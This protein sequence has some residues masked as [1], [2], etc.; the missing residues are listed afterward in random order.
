MS[1]LEIESHHEKVI[2]PWQPAA[3][4]PAPQEEA[5]ADEEAQQPA[6]VE[7]AGPDAQAAQAQLFGGM[8]GDTEPATEKHKGGGKHGGDKDKDKDKDRAA[9]DPDEKAKAKKVKALKK[10]IKKVHKLDKEAAKLEAEGKDDE[11]EKKREESAKLKQKAID[12][13]IDAYDID[14]SNAKFVKYDAATAG[15]GG[16]NQRAE[17]R[18][19]DAAFSSASWLGSTLGHESEIH[20]NEQLKKGNWY[21]GAQ[22]TALQEVQAY[23]YEIDNAKRFGTSKKDLKDLKQRRKSHM[24]ALSHDYQERARDG[25]YTMKHGE[26]NQ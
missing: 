16:A 25:N 2:D 7:V 6:A 14:V 12:K 24:D 19:G 26:E 17:I 15:E 18:L 21:T 9:K 20:I 4:A 13:A 10:V 5:G 23:Q 11:A 8:Y 22:G 1:A 3:V